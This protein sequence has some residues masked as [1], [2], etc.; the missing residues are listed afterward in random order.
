MRTVGS[1]R[2]HAL[3]PFAAEPYPRLPLQPEREKIPMQWY[4]KV[5]QQHFADFN[6]R[7]RR[8]EYWMFGLFNAI[9][10]LVLSL[11]S[12]GLMT[13]TEVAA[14]SF[15]PVLYALAVLIPSLALT[16]R[17][18]HD[19]GKSGWFVFITMVPF[20]GSLAFLYFMVIDSTPGPNQYGPNPKGY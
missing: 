17:R 14:F 9:V 20:I 5:L 15:V 6:G 18:L 16:V 12:T 4:L 10:L 3:D 1:T 19:T 11:V 7:A 2:A 13:A 8:M